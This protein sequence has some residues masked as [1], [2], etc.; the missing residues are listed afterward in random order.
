MGV[1]WPTFPSEATSSICDLDPISSCLFRTLLLKL[2]HI[3]TYIHMVRGSAALSCTLEITNLEIKQRA[4]EMAQWL[5]ALTVLTK[6]QSS[7]PINHIVAH[8]HL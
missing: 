1:N 8:N 6:V 4:G 7:N 3:I 5:R 2:T